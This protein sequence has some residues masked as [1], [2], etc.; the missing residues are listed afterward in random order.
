MS[1]PHHQA[2][3]L[4]PAPARLLIPVTIRA[5]AVLVFMTV[6]TVVRPAIAELAS[7]TPP[8]NASEGR[9]LRE[10]NRLLEEEIIVA[11]KAQVYLLADLSLPAILIK[12]RG[13][14]LYRLPIQSWQL[15]GK[16]AWPHL[17]RVLQRP[18]VDR[19]EARIGT[20]ATADPVELVE[21]PAEFLLSCDPPLQVSVRPPPGQQPWYWAR[22]QART[23]WQ[24]LSAWLRGL[25]IGSPPGQPWLRL[26]LLAEDARSLAWALTDDM[27]LLIGRSVK[28]SGGNQ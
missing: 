9:H 14:E 19:T 23:A 6:S 7:P 5:A 13:I 27:P 25:A 21:M 16:V 20:D 8:Q 11:S 26:T 12:A 10:A 24:M 28:E 1:S 4:A 17:Y 22:N 3:S 18:P 15:S 2:A